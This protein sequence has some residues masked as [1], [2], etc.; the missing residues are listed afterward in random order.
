MYIKFKV[1]LRIVKFYFDIKEQDLLQYISSGKIFYLLRTINQ[2]TSFVLVTL[3]G[4][5]LQSFLRSPPAPPPSK[6]VTLFPQT[7]PVSVLVVNLSYEH[8]DLVV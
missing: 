8:Y 1:H 4:I 7:N 2:N 5:P 6:C 3:A